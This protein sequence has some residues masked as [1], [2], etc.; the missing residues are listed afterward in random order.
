[1]YLKEGIFL[2]VPSLSFQRRQM[3]GFHDMRRSLNEIDSIILLTII[4]S[5]YCSYLHLSRKVFVH[6]ALTYKIF[7]PL[8]QTSELELENFFSTFGE[9]TDVRIV[10]DRK[11]GFNKG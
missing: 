8:S 10:C 9:V 3:Q 6:V 2:Q 4:W 11:T 1:M 7:F 5:S